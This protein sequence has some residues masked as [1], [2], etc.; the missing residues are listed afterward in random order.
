MK[1]AEYV[2]R[3]LSKT[4]KALESASI[5]SLPQD[6]QLLGSTQT[7]RDLLERAHIFNV[8]EAED[9]DRAAQ[10]ILPDLLEECREDIPAPF[11]NMLVLCDTGRGWSCEWHIRAQPYLP[12]SVANLP[13]LGNFDTSSTCRSR[14]LI[15]P[16]SR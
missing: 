14:C 5:R 10:E 13:D 3:V 6:L 12:P 16:S 7:L 1:F 2:E 4:S 11:D 9:L 15:A 8:G